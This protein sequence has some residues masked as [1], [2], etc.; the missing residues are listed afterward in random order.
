MTRRGRG[1]RSLTDQ[2]VRE[3]VSW[4]PARPLPDPLAVAVGA[5]TAR[6]DGRGSGYSVPASVLLAVA[7]AG[8]GIGALVSPARR[9]ARDRFWCVVT[10]HRLRAGL[11]EADVR[12]WSGRMPAIV[13]TSVRPQG[14]QVLLACPAGVDAARIAAAGGELAAACWAVDVTVAPHPRHANLTTVD[15]V[16]RSAEEKEAAV[17]SPR[18]CGNG[19][20]RNRWR[21]LAAE[22][23][24][25]IRSGEYELGDR[26]PSNSA[27]RARYGVSGQT[28][29]HAMNSLRSEGLVETRAGLGWLRVSPLTSSGCPGA[30]SRAA[31]CLRTRG[32]G[33]ARRRTDG[34]ATSS[35]C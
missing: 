7:G 18:L 2:L 3:L 9:L 32:W 17:T 4:P 30:P 11:R 6:G 26:L 8:V 33:A 10:Q 19:S 23:R 25:S 5:G 22:L 29:Q 31:A 16:R 1:S 12:S 20:D 21:P 27:L 28:V 24:R 13:W 35:P 15:V 34:C 14:E